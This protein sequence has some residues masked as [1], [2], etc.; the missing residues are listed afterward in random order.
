MHRRILV[1]ASAAAVLAGCPPSHDVTKLAPAAKSSTNSDFSSPLDATLSPD[2]KMAYFIAVLPEITSDVSDTPMPAHAG[3]F[4]TKVGS[5][6]TNTLLASGDP[7][8]SPINLDITADG[9]TL[10]IADTAA[11]AGDADRGM[12]FMLDAAGG[13]PKQVDATVGYR[14]R[15]MAVVNQDWKDTAYFTGNDPADGLPGVFALDI[16]TGAV[17]AKSKSDLFVD[18]SGIVVADNGDIYVV[19]TQ[20]GDLLANV[21]QIP[22]GKDPVELLSGLKV[23]YPAGISISKDQQILTVSALDPVTRKDLVLR[24][25][26]KLGA[27]GDPLAGDIIKDF[28]ESAGLHRAKDVESYVWADSRANG[29]GTVYVINQVQ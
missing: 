29:G 9:K 17:T 10:I 16:K 3:I 23:G 11:G 26:L 28:E 2:G 13:T 18:P 15:G 4:S 5:E 12:L 14:A 21:I 7:L 27:Y 20:T 19:D 25:D 6:G 1:A 8:A 24:Y 22:K